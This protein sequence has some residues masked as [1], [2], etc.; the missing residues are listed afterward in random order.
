MKNY[1]H[2][3]TPVNNKKAQFSNQIKTHKKSTSIIG[4][5][6]PQNS[7]MTSTRTVNHI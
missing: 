1:P 7:K 3:Y 2:L 4:N 6:T 5:Q